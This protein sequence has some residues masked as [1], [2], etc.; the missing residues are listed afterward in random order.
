MRKLVLFLCCFGFIQTS[1]S[2]IYE[3]S[4]SIDGLKQQAGS[5]I[6]MD[7]QGNTYVA[8]IIYDTTD[9]SG[10]SGIS[11]VD[12]LKGNTTYGTGIVIKYDASGVKQWVCALPKVSFGKIA[13]HPSGF[14]YFVGKYSTAISITTQFGTNTYPA[15]PASIDVIVGRIDSSTGEIHSTDVFGNFGGNPDAIYVDGLADNMYLSFSMSSIGA[16]TIHGTSYP[17]SSMG[18]NG[19]LVKLNASNYSVSWVNAFE[20]SF[21]SELK[22]NGLGITGQSPFETVFIAGTFAETVDLDVSVSTSNISSNGWDGFMAK[23]AAADGSYIGSAVIGSNDWSNNNYINSMQLSSEATNA[24]VIVAGTFSATCDFDP[25]PGNTTQLPSIQYFEGFVA[26]Y[27]ANFVYQS[28]ISLRGNETQRVVSLSVPSVNHQKLVVIGQADGNLAYENAQFD[29][30]TLVQ[31]NPASNVKKPFVL[32]LGYDVSSIWVENGF[33]LEG[34][35]SNGDKYIGSRRTGSGKIEVAALVNLQNTLDMDPSSFQTIYSNTSTPSTYYDMVFGKYNSN[36]CPTDT[37]YAVT[38]CASNYV[39]GNNTLTASGTYS[40][41]VTNAN[42]CDSTITLNLTLLQPTSST[43]NV[44]QCGSYIAP[45][46]AIYTTSGTFF[47]TIPNSSNCD[48]IITINLT[49]NPIPVATALQNNDGTLSVS[50]GTLIQWINC[51][52]NQP[53]ANANEANYTPTENGLYAAI[54]SNNA[55][56][57]D[58]SNCLA[59]TNVGISEMDQ[60]TITIYPN[61]AKDQ[62]NISSTLMINQIQVCDLSGRILLNEMVSNQFQSTIN[63]NDFANGTYQVVVLTPNGNKTATII[64][65]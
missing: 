50:G 45:S 55:V 20:G 3:W 52:T 62:L 59:V 18:L 35:A 26:L 15:P 22:I 1:F 12:T 34:G 16:S 27:D 39:F 47:D 23:Y 10:S 33:F 56:C 9:L 48:S 44:S 6:K 24:T 28:G 65:N 17:Q 29:V 25:A 42:G 51:A 8:G 13:V 2:Q 32:W 43:I 37:M 11:M 61:P 57:S 14:V 36:L 46:G 40:R 49:V 31:L 38:S 54:V 4:K 41:V 58:T 63:L 60:N 30:D 64:K 5:D 19:Y 7:A 21:Y 53:I